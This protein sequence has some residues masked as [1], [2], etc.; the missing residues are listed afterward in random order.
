MNRW[1]KG[2]L[3]GVGVSAVTILVVILLGGEKKK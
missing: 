2:L 3:I 1:V